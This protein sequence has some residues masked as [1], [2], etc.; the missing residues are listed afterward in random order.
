VDRAAWFDCVGR[1]NQIVNRLFVLAALGATA[2]TLAA[3]APALNWRDVAEPEL[4][5]QAQFPCKPQRVVQ[6]TMGLLQ[7][8]AAGQRFVLAWRRFDEPAQ[9]RV[10][11]AQGAAH[12]AKE[13]Q[14]KLQNSPGVQVPK[15]AVD[16]PGSGRFALNGGH[17]AAW[18][19][20]WASG[21]VFHQALVVAPT[22]TPDEAARWFFDSLRE[23]P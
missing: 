14:A 5:L 4:R 19:Q 22:S 18:V 15:G 16:W 6:A 13:L 8:E 7:C 1:D 2:W 17:R 21:L 23:Q 10:A 12:A 3:C 9:A 20:I 11:V